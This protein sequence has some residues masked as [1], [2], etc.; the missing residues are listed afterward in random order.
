MNKVLAVLL[1][2]FLVGCSTGPAPTPEVIEVEKIIIITA[3]PTP[4]ED[5][6]NAFEVSKYFDGTLGNLERYKLILEVDMLEL[7]FFMPGKNAHKDLTLFK[8]QSILQAQSQLEPPPCL[9][10][11]DELM[12]KSF[13]SFA[14]AIE[15]VAEYD[16]YDG[17]T[18]L[19]QQG[20]E[21]MNEAIELV[22]EFFGGVSD[23]SVQNDRIVS[24]ES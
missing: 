22:D 14:L 7:D 20:T 2:L 9:E 3:T 1:A 21:Y 11:V 17:S 13:E 23:S 18:E 10:D 12:V 4:T 6:C 5:S 24:S 8:A 19:L 15:R 16:D